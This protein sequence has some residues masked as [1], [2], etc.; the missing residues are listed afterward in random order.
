MRW[1]QFKAILWLRWRLSRNQFSR[2]GSFSAAISIVVMVLLGGGAAALGAGG[3]FGGLLAGGKAKPEV[4]L[5]IFD[6][7]IL[8]FLFAWLAG[9]LAELQRS[10]SIDLGKLLHLPVTLKQVFL[11]NFAAAHLS[12]ILLLFVPATAGFCIGLSITGGLRMLLL[13]PVIGVVILTITAWTYC[14]R[15]WLAGLMA[16]KRRRTALGVWCAIFTI[17][18][19]QLPG[20]VIKKLDLGKNA[21][22]KRLKQES[23]I[24]AHA[25]VP[26]GWIGYSAMGLKRHQPWPSAGFVL[27]GLLMAAA[28]VARSYTLTERFYKGQDTAR[29]EKRSERRKV[30]SST[31]LV[32][33]KIPFLDDD[34]AG[35]ATATLRSILR[36]PEFRLT[37]VM[38]A[39]ILLLV[40]GSALGKVRGRPNMELVPFAITGGV[41][42]IPLTLAAIMGNIFGMDRGGFRAL[43]LSPMPR[44][45]ML[46]ARNVAFLP[47]V[48]IGSFL[49]LVLAGVFFRASNLVL[50]TGGFQAVTGF[51]LFCVLY[52]FLSILAPYRY[53]MNSLQGKKFKPVVLVATLA[54]LLVWPFI[55]AILVVPP[56]AQFLAVYLGMPAWIPLNLTLAMALCALAVWGYWKV[57]P[58]QGRLLQQRE[59]RILP[60]VTL[61]TE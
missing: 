14:L 28:G 24:K 2:A 32:S 19:A 58:A 60:E 39:V 51:V 9:L 42:L 54:S 15:G 35:L 46:L 56:L 34:T 45:K 25:F 30:N 48:L 38:P 53:S 22:S 16:N 52:N 49:V 3:L 59:T 17:G 6:G 12:P 27:L 41:L 11:F 44:A 40:F 18:L 33:R 4:L 8:L 43:M 21:G 36:S 55:V 26:P 29:R 1:E 50:L 7:L 31:L 47:V 5:L 13:L 23:F 20:V 37:L 10:E 57:L 61:E